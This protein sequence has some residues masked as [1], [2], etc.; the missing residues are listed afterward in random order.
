MKLRQVDVVVDYLNA[1]TIKLILRSGK[2]FWGFCLP[3]ASN[4]FAFFLLL[5]FVSA[6]VGRQILLQ[7]LLLTEFCGHGADILAIFR[8]KTIQL[9]TTNQ[10]K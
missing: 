8:I 9:H 1:K 6:F 4:R 3:L 7:I 2:T 10:Q 5:L